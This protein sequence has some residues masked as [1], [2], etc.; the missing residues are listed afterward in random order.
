LIIEE[1]EEEEEEKE[2]RKGWRAGSTSWVESEQA[3]TNG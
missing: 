3:V 1:E 2:G